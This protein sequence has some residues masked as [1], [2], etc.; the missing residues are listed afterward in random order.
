MPTDNWEK[1]VNRGVGRLNFANRSGKAGVGKAGFAKLIV[2]MGECV[3][4]G[5]VL[6]GVNV[7]LRP[8]GG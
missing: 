4:G 7:S 2:V 5:I 8:I 1:P 6:Y 3:F